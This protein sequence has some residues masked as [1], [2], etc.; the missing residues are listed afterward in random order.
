M[1]RA[2]TVLAATVALL[3]PACGPDRGPLFEECAAECGLDVVLT[4]GG[5]PDRKDTI[6]EVNGNGVALS[7]LAEAG[8]ELGGRVDALLGILETL[9][10]PLA[11]VRERLDIRGMDREEA[12][13]ALAEER[14]A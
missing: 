6:L 11:E 10:E 4:C 12:R 14:G 3:A 7:D 9:Q 2:A 1:R 5:S 8:T 13:R